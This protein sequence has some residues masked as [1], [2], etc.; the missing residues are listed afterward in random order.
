[1]NANINTKQPVISVK[2]LKKKFVFWAERPTNLKSF[3]VEL[4]K[5]KVL[6][7]THT[8][9]TVLDG[10]SFDIYPGEFVG[11]MGRNGAGKS[12]LMRLLSGIYEPTEGT[13]Q[14]N[15]VVA[16][17]I[18]LGAG[19]NPELTGYE[20]IFLNAAI[21]GFGRKRTVEALDS[22]IEFSELG[23]H[24][25][26][27]IKNYSSGMVVRLGF[28]IA[29]HLD[30]EI[31]LLDEVLGVGDEGFMTK[32]LNKIHQLHA[33]GRTILLVTHSPAAIAQFCSRCIVI[34]NGV[35]VFDGPAK[36]GAETYHQLFV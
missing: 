13:L 7:Q 31:L 17:L 19:F 20:N 1:M 11:L 14:I 26:R 30:A 10:V 3:L 27:P 5:G 33:E 16:P 15:G 25:H 2:N 8:Q 9:V 23:E 4:M 6:R 29:S 24:I 18:S 12:T 35:K 36:E 34:N 21:L 32:S 22:I 28:S